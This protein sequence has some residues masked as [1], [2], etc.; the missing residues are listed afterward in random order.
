M[1]NPRL[2]FLFKFLIIKN[3]FFLPF[4]FIFLNHLPS[5]LPIVPI[6]EKEGGENKKC[7]RVWGL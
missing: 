5:H 2:S 1:A 6:V 7:P 3:I 4:Y